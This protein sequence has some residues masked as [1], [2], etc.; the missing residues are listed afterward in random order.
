MGPLLL[1]VPALLGTLHDDSVS[2]SRLE[3]GERGVSINLRVQA[4]SVLEV[5]PWM[6]LDGDQ[7]LSAEEL[8]ARPAELGRYLLNHYRLFAGERALQ[9]ETYPDLRQDPAAAL[10]GS[11]IQACWQV[12]TPTS[13]RELQL[14]VELFLEESP[15]HLEFTEVSWRGTPLPPFILRS[16]G[17][18]WSFV[19]PTV[20]ASAAAAVRDLGARPFVWAL[21]MLAAALAC[22]PA[23]RTRVVGVA[24]AAAGIAVLWTR[25]GGA[26][27]PTRPVELAA[28]L[29]TA[30]V[31]ADL[32]L[33]RRA[34]PPWLEAAAFGLLIGL[35]HGGTAATRLAGDVQADVRLAVEA[36]VGAALAMSVAALIVAATG[37]R[38][39]RALAGALAVAGL[40]LFVVRAF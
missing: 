25:I 27:P 39:R 40:A 9:P 12:E 16:T 17:R 32:A 23:P 11:W 36:A 26:L 14:E 8:A 28:V 3:V 20:R 22:G 2:F 6:D 29:G 18:T 35:A 15:G 13:L 21:V 10:P 7:L 34:R 5:T 19:Q 30:Y 4:L 31:A 1:V 24:V 38:A 37:E 33:L